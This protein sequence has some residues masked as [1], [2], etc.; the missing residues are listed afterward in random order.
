MHILDLLYR[1]DNTTKNHQIIRNLATDA[2]DGIIRRYDDR[3]IQDTFVA[4]N[5]RHDIQN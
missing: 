3:V 1:N 2:K 4:A 5:N